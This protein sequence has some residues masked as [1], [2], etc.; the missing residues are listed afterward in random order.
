MTIPAMER[1]PAHAPSGRLRR[2]LLVEEQLDQAHQSQAQV[3][4]T[5]P[6]V[7]DF[8]VTR[9]GQSRRLT[10]FL[11]GYCVERGIGYVQYTMTEGIR[12]YATLPDGEAV[13]VRM[14]NPGDTP[15]QAVQQVIT[16]LR[17]A[18]TAAMLVFDYADG[19]LDADR[20]NLEVSLLCEQLQALTADNGW[21]KAG[22]RLVLVD[23]GGG[24]TPRLTSQ[25][26][27]R[28]VHVGPPD[29]AELTIFARQAAQATVTAR[30]HLAD[31]LSEE[32]TGRR[33]GGLL[34]LHLHEIRLT[35]TPD[36]PVTAEQIAD[37]KATAIRDTSGRTLE[38]M[39]A[40]V[41]FADD[42]AGLPAV[43]LALEDAQRAGRTTLR[44]LL[45]GP[46][47]TGKTLAATAIAA[48][49]NVPA[50][51]YGEIL[52]EFVGVAERNMTRANQ[53][54]RAMAPLVLF[55]D[56]ADQVGLGARG[57]AAG[58]SEVHQNLR[59]ALFE[60][61][62]DTGEQ[63]GITVVAT[64]NVPM[65]LDDAA[66]S[67]FNVLP[68]LFASATELIQIMGIHARRL[69][70]TLDGDL[71][72]VMAGYARAGGVLSGRSAVILLEAAHVQALRAGERAV[73]PRHVQ[74]A[75]SGWVGNDWTSAAEYST[76]SSLITARHADAWP[77]VAATRL[78][79]TYEI[80][81]YL[82]SYLTSAGELDVARMRD[83]VAELSGSHVFS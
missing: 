73:A 2:T 28:T 74:A 10:A 15:A 14:A 52:N 30:L 67:R 34:N 27:I 21:H 50:V 16:D 44:I 53:V 25:P 46:P 23:R 54:L 39:S 18:A 6:G 45:S 75:L 4:L 19:I 71:T 49:L 82:R 35:S 41:S 80:P 5:G 43:R 64:T 38:L 55:I 63:T 66:L 3:L 78:G 36:H 24:I 81:A 31:G 58:S 29:Q 12:N 20:L 9:T 40:R 7:H 57:A 33:A 17:E 47:G 83:R 70:I 68:V 59:A 13:K 76:L 8:L 69:G 48:A 42:V 72:E 26:G 62:G 32:E 56:E 11:H 22:L 61:L 51:R 79:E 37:F 1:L 60:F 77:W 65:R